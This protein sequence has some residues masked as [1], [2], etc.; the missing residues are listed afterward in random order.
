[1]QQSRLD[2]YQRNLGDKVK[3]L[4]IAREFEPGV[5]RFAEELEQTERDKG[6]TDVEL[7]EWKPNKGTMTLTPYSSNTLFTMNTK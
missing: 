5:K 2:S 6:L 4:W 7:W 3:V 1:L